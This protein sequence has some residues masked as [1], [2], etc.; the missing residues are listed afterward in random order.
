MCLLCLI[1]HLNNFSEIG[2][3]LMFNIGSQVL[4]KAI[5][6]VWL[7]NLCFLSVCEYDPKNF[8]EVLLNTLHVYENYV[9]NVK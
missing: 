8:P 2:P 3:N 1:F 5:D 6:C 9:K 4:Y 7:G